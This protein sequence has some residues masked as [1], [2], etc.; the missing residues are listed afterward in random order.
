LPPLVSLP[1]LVITHGAL[2]H[3][4]RSLSA[5]LKADNN[6]VREWSRE[7]G[8]DCRDENS[9]VALLLIYSVEANPGGLVLFS[10]RSTDRVRHNAKAVFDPK[11][12]PSQAR[13]FAQ[14]V[15]RDM[16]TQ[17]KYS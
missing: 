12:A 16:L 14:L 5:L 10:A 9:L 7:L 11:I 6:K 1:G 2:A 17:R 15:E 13:L 4:Y 3:A 8:L